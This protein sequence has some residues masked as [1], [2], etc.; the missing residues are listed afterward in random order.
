MQETI[1]EQLLENAIKTFLEKNFTGG[2]KADRED[3]IQMV[4]CK[5]I[6]DLYTV[7]NQLKKTN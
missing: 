4:S 2:A 7:Y 3:Y 1:K 5:D 6:Y